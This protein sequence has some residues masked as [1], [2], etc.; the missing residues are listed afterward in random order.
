MNAQRR[1]PFAPARPFTLIEML[2][3]IA[4][5]AILAALLTPALQKALEKSRTVT[6][7]NNER[8]IGIASVAY[9]LDNADRLPN[10][11][12]WG[13]GYG[14]SGN[15]CA[16]GSNFWP[17]HVLPYSGK[18]ATK[19]ADVKQTIFWCPNQ[20]KTSH[21]KTDG[22]R[23]FNGWE[24]NCYG[25]NQ[26]INGKNLKGTP[27]LKAW[28]TDGNLTT[29]SDNY[30]QY[31]RLARIKNGGKVPF[32]ADG[33]TN[34]CTFSIDDT[35]YKEGSGAYSLRHENYR[36][37]CVLFADMHAVPMSAFSYCY[38]TTARSFSSYYA[39]DESF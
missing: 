10:K 21:L 29:T 34:N 20:G 35:Y 31:A 11:G 33:G 16:Y 36:T 6:C 18:K 32:V 39:I 30:F 9:S 17:I 15:K 2:V 28:N 14:R 27:N 3:V 24:G 8:Q 13:P 19:I 23:Y 37:I 25:T 12:L 38:D 5:I 22:T 7:I 1:L 4:I 26:K